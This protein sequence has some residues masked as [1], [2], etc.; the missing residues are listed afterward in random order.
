MK[1]CDGT[2]VDKREE[3][4]DDKGEK[5]RVEGNVPIGFDLDDEGREREAA[6]TG[7]R[8]GLA[9]DR[10]DSAD[11]S[12]CNV[13]NDNGSHDRSAGITLGNIIKGLNEGVSSWGKDDVHGVAKGEAKGDSHDEA[14]AAV[15]S[16]GSHDGS[17][18]DN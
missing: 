5:N 11:T 7:K 9:R 13:D 1:G 16:G 12:G 4:R 8:P 15:D 2:D 14:H 18:E 10:G 6:I 17:G 3:R